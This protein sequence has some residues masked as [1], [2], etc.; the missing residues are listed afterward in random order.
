MEFDPIRA[1][2]SAT[3]LDALAARLETELRQSLPALLVQPAGLDEVSG[4]AAATLRDAA[5]SY[6]EAAVQGIH[7]IRKLAAALRSQSDLLVRMDDE[8]A[9]GFSAAN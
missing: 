7:E 8:N 9:S 2:Q 4:R 6:D 1:G 3:D 5:S